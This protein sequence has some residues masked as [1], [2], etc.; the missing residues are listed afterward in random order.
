MGHGCGPP[1]SIAPTHRANP[2]GTETPHHRTQG[3]SAEWRDRPP[4]RLLG[5]TGVSSVDVSQLLSVAGAQIGAA[6]RRLPVAT[7]CRKVLPL[8]NVSPAMRMRH[9]VTFRREELPEADATKAHGRAP[10]PEGHDDQ[11]PIAA[12]TSRTAPTP[13]AHERNR[14]KGGV[15]RVS[16]QST[17]RQ[18]N[19]ARGSLNGPSLA[20]RP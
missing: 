10:S 19:A 6:C 3:Q 1:A 14:Q 8:E 12:T 2:I 11:S 7:P 5:G 17:P 4:E 18:H 15:V 20:D 9:L 13:G 16:T